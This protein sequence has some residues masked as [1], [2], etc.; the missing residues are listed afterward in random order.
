M[1]NTTAGESLWSRTTVIKKDQR[2][3]KAQTGSHCAVMRYV[4]FMLQKRTGR[5]HGPGVNSLKHGEICKRRSLWEVSTCEHL[6]RKVSW[7][8]EGFHE[9]RQTIK[10][11]SLLLLL[12][13][14]L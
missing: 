11:I 13:L 6:Y 8:E 1:K 10:R 3:E 5:K 14:T 12:L 4:R 9:N 7:E 2:R